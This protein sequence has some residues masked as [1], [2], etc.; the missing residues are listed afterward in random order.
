MSNV[1]NTSL[2]LINDKIQFEGNAGSNPPVI[3]DYVP[4]FGDGSGYTSLELL[5]LSLSSCSASSILILLRKMKKT[6]SSFEV[7][8]SG[9]RRDVHPTYFSFIT[10]EFILKS[11]DVTNEDMQKVIS[12]SEETYCPVWGMIKHSCVI[13][14]SHTIL[15]D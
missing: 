10:L 14:T 13:T 5:L 7:K 8:A 6:I 4:P 15:P 3:I 11:P 9:T 1:L 12:L 2:K